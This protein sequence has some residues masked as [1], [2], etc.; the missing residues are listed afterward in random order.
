MLGQKKKKSNTIKTNDT[1]RENK[2]EGRQ[3]YRDRIKQYRQNRT[4]Q[5]DKKNSTSKLV[6]EG[7]RIHEDIPK[8][9]ELEAKQFLGKIWERREHH[10]KTDWINKDKELLGLKESPKTKILLNLLRAKLKEVANWKTPGNGSKHVLRFEKFTSIH[11]KLALEINRRLEA[12]IPEW[13][14]EGKTTQI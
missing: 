3:R 4:F 14:I 13:M 6:R 8:S 7:R 12:G 1:T 11:L 2:S 9:D 5:N 10:R